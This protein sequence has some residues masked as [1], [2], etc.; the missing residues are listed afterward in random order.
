MN[1]VPLWQAV[2]TVVK[3]IH[4]YMKMIRFISMCFFGFNITSYDTP[5][6][7]LKSYTW[8]SGAAYSVQS[9]L[10]THYFLFFTAI[11]PLLNIGFSANI[12]DALAWLWSLL[13]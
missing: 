5:K 10:V 2:S 4:E 9:T 12:G 6:G 1:S 8:R 3:V 13:W 7:V 11:P